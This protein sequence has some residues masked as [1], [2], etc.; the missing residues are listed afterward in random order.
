LEAEKTTS[1]LAQNR[2]AEAS[3]AAKDLAAGPKQQQNEDQSTV[4]MSGKITAALDQ[5]P[6]E[7][8]RN[9]CW[10][11]AG[12]PFLGQRTLQHRL[13]QRLGTLLGSRE[14]ENP[15]CWAG[16]RK[17]T[18]NGGLGARRKAT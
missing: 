6:L 5:N 8:Q 3:W 11:P 16:R 9:Q 13:D 12:E 7:S 18:S 4:L 2:K 14:K 1:W 10:K 17:I 15:Q